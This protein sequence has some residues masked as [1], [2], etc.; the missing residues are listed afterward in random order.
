MKTKSILLAAL[1]T[2]GASASQTFAQDTAPNRI[3]VTDV[4]GSYTGFNLDYTGDIRFATVEGTVGCKIDI[5]NVAMDVIDINVSSTPAC[6]SFAI[7]FVKTIRANMLNDAS[8]IQYVAQNGS[9][10][11]ASFSGEAQISDLDLEQGVD[12]TLLTVAY[13]LYGIAGSVSRTEL[14]TPPVEIL[15]NPHVEAEIVGQTEN[16]FTIAFTPN[17]DVLEYYYMAFD[18][19]TWEEYLA[20]WGPMF[21]CDNISQLIEFWY[22]GMDGYTEPMVA[23]FGPQSDIEPGT[24]YEVIIAVKDLNGNFIPHETIIASTLTHGGTGA[25]YVDI[26]IG[27]YE[28]AD[29]WGE[30]KPSQFITYKPNAE[31]N[32]YRF[33]VYDAEDYDRFG[34]LLH[35]ELCSDPPQPGIA[36]WWFFEETETDY[37]CNPEHDYVAIAA[38]KNALGEWGKVNVVRFTTPAIQGYPSS[39]KSHGMKAPTRKAI[40]DQAIS[41]G[42][43]VS[44]NMKTRKLR[45]EPK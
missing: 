14:S 28:L 29:W 12:Y 30:I 32:R 44:K 18:E 1:L 3:L 26:E 2:V 6:V 5:V 40:K 9:G 17:Q 15:G 13:D 42:I 23:E 45:I 10:Q 7:A 36:Y 27:K 41:K 11:I 22:M 43:T 38:G 37:Q 8:A 31:T 39:A 21:N 34:E 33:E 24:V 4:N 25:A 16:S 20:M 19:G 35:E